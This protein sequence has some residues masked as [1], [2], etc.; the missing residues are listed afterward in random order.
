MK[1]KILITINDI[2][3]IDK[4][5][6]LGIT[7][8]VFPL[9]DYCVGIPNTFLIEEI[10]CEG[11]LYINRILDNDGIDGLKE[12]LRNI[13]SKIKGIIFDDLGVLEVIKDMDLEKILYLSHFNT[14]SESI[15]I[16][17]D[18]VDTVIVSTDITKEEIEYIINNTKKEISLFIFGYVSA[19]YSRRL[20]LNNY[21][22]F[23]NIDK[24]NPLE[25]D[26]TGNKF[27]VYENEYG[28]A[29]YPKI[30]F[31]GLELLELKAKYYFFNSVFLRVEEIEDVLNGKLDGLITSKHFLNKETIYK[32]KDGE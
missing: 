10:P 13:D 6:K 31:N 7:K 5:K 17:L 21:S 25:I 19:M 14:N 4:L 15:N 11:Y 1:N 22:D 26:N 9:K 29:F 24:V 27:I 30:I 28:T 16:Y 23:Y 12:I 18:Y 2:N 3:S 20:L 32:L 8:Y